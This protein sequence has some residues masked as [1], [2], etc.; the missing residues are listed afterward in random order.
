[1]TPSSVQSKSTPITMAKDTITT[2]AKGTTTISRS[3][4][5]VYN[6]PQRAASNPVAQPRQRSTKHKRITMNQDRAREG[7]KRE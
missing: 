3:S 2:D 7:I 1:M 5:G 4:R 6:Y